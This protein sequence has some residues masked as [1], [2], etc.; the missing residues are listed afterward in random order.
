[1]EKINFVRSKHIDQ[2]VRMIEITHSVYK[3]EQ[4]FPR[5]K[6]VHLDP[7]DPYAWGRLIIELIREYTR[8]YFVEQVKDN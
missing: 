1:M 7:D 3:K 5:M 6:H 8:P 2:Y 4:Y